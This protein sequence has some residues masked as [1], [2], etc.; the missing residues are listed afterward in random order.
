MSGCRNNLRQLGVAL[1]G[2][3][4]HK[5]R[6]PPGGPGNRNPI[7]FGYLKP[8]RLGSFLVLLLPYIEEQP[9]Y[10][11]CDPKIDTVMQATMPDGTWVASANLSL[12]KCPSDQIDG[13]LDGN[14]L[15]HAW[16]VSMKGRAP[17]RSNYAFSMGSQAFTGPYPG[18][19]FGNGPIGH[20]DTVDANQVSGIFSHADF[21]ATLQDVSDG[22]SKTFAVGEMRPK[23]SVHAADGWMHFNSLWNATS[24]PMNYPTC[25]GEPGF[26]AVLVNNF[27]GGKWATEQA[28]RSRHVGGANFAMADGSVHFVSDM[29]D[30]LTYQKLGDRRDGRVVSISAP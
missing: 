1:H 3:A 14:P 2:Y 9:I 12:L 15:Y 6:F 26:D 28:F 7:D 20:G 5:K 27:W 16:P 25:P 19:V 22:L 29:I 30:Y 21:G 4:H 17:G 11:R 10:D 13:P 23:C 18:N 24:A 8:G